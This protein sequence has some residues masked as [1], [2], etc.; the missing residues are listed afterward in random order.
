MSREVYKIEHRAFELNEYPKDYF[1][2]YGDPF[3]GHETELEILSFLVKASAYYVVPVMDLWAYSYAMARFGTE[4]FSR[5]IDILYIYPTEESWDY[6][7][8]LEVEFEYKLGKL[9]VEI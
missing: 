8:P 4:F 6:G 1:H 9:N 2:F 3:K 7:V 5:N